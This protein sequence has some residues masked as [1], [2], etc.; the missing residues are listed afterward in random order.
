M[1]LTPS[2][3]SLMKPASPNECLEPPFC[4]GDAIPNTGIYRAHHLEHRPCHEVTLLRNEIF[5][6]CAR[7]GDSVVFEL[8]RSV[9]GL[10]EKDFRIRLYKIP[11]LEAT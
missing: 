4:V 11:D 9:P 2:K 8:V 1:R 3:V 10:E 7:C 5:P 6:P